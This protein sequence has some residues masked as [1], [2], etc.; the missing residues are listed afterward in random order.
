MSPPRESPRDYLLAV[1]H[2]LVTSLGIAKVGSLCVTVDVCDTQGDPVRLR[3]T[4]HN[5][6]SPCR[7]EQLV[8]PP[9]WKMLSPLE[10]QVVELLRSRPGWVT[11]EE[12]AT[13]VGESTS[14]DLRPILRN[15]AARSVLESAQGRGYRLARSGTA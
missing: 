8:D 13:A 2:S 10:E 12:I 6:A 11:A 3:F 4:S 7:G 14:G 1:A 9:G 15:L 5:P